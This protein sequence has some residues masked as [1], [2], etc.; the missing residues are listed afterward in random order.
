[1]DPKEY[2]K[3]LTTEELDAA[4]IA[5]TYR[6]FPV[7]I[8]G[9]K[10]SYLFS[11]DGKTYIDMGT[12]IAVNSFGVS[13]PLW[14]YAVTQQMMQ[15][16][17][18]SNLYYNRMAACLAS[19]MCERTGMKKVF[20]GNSGAEA[21]ECAIKTARKYAKAA[22]GDDCYKIITLNGSFHGR[23]VT[24]LAATGQ[25]VFHKDF[26]PLTEG[27]LYL[28]PED[29]EG[30]HALVASEKIAA[31]L[32]EPV[33]GEGGVRALS[34]AFVNEMARVAKENDILLIADEV[35]I[36]NGRSGELY[37]YMHYGIT[38][39]IVTTA[40]GLGGGLPIGAC[41][42]GEKCE[43]T[44]TYGDHGSTFGANPLA[45]AGAVSIYERLDA[46]CL[47]GVR[48][49]SAYIFD[50]LTGADG[51][52]SVSG[53]GLMIGVETVRPA[54]EVVAACRERGVLVLTAKTKVRLLP[55]LNI[56]MDTL[57]AAIEILKSV[58]AEKESK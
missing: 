27:F 44:L 14:N 15:F 58:C 39:D 12:G 10:G 26:L 20:F 38:P 23:T 53:L 24:T 49:R 40:K 51:I 19:M 8:T 52:K 50:A 57:R 28:E 32:F 29:I 3:E 18:I 37:G 11:A 25:E 56:P 9:G 48:E 55:A 31:I 43:Y 21:N 41:L 54:S 13:D 2:K 36:G 46:A 42:F 30:L 16:Q 1:M 35:Q 45:V 4:Y 5:N 47:Q 6:R 34:E 7:E 22:H 33:Q 17:H